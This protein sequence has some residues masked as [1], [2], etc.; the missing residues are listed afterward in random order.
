MCTKHFS[1][2]FCGR[3]P[4]LLNSGSQFE[5]PWHPKIVDMVFLSL[6]TNRKSEGTA[7]RQPGRKRIAGF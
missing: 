2:A 4:E 5:I 3:G 7:K 1:K 6:D